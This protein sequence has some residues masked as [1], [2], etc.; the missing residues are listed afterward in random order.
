MCA[1]RPLQLR[2]ENFF[3]DAMSLLD[4]VKF[5][6]RIGR[7]PPFSDFVDTQTDP[8]LDMQSDSD[9]LK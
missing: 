8:S 7:E 2:D 1:P 5:I 9:I 3:S 4:V 6:Q